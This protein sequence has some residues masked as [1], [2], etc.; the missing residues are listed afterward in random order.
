MEQSPRREGERMRLAVLL[1]CLVVSTASFADERFTGFDH[2][3]SQYQSARAE[4]RP[5]LTRAFVE[6]QQAHGGFPIVEPTGHAVFFY[7]GT[8]QEKDVRLIGEFRR[9]GYYNHAWDPA[10]VPLVRAAEGGAVFFTRLSFEKDARLEYKFVIDGAEKPDPLNP[11]T[12]DGAIVGV[13]SEV[14]MPGYVPPRE[15]VAR[16][17]VPKGSLHVVEEPWATPKVTIYLPAKY[18]AAKRYPV[19]YTPD[20]AAWINHLKLPIIL[21]NLIAEGSIEPVIAVMTDPTADRSNW[22]QFNPDYLSYLE[23]VVAYVDSHY[24][25]R[26]RAEDRLHLGTSA[27]GRIALYVGLERPQLFRNVALLSPSLMGP[28]SYYEPWFS[29]RRRPNPKLRIWLSAGSYEGYIV[30]DTQMLETYFKS[31]GLKP[32]TVYTHQGHSLGAWRYL[33][34]DVLRYFLGTKPR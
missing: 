34:P 23:K 3:V 27:G 13:V 16:E 24:S 26:A 19:I 18:D 21:D 2:F 7:V 6:W 32:K 15:A 33:A 31:V 1:L 11:R 12:Y 8:G 29:R 25:T 30:Q 20:G 28:P 22:Y 5:E 17:D 4:A 14:S 9:A 10:G